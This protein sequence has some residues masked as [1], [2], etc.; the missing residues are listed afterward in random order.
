[1]SL[2]LTFSDIYTKVHNFTTAP[3]TPTGDDL[4]AAKDIVYRA[5]RRF[6]Y[7]VSFVTKKPHIWSW[8]IKEATLQLEAGKDTYLLPEDFDDLHRTFMYTMNTGRYGAITKTSMNKLMM[9]KSYNAE[10]SWPLMCATH[11][12]T[13]SKTVDQNKKVIFWPAP[14]GVYQ[15][16]YSYV[17]EPPKPTVATDLFLGNA[18]TDET[19]LQVCLAVAEQESDEIVG[20]QSQLADNQV[21][22]L[23]LKDTNDAPDTVGYVRDG[24]IANYGSMRDWVLK[25]S[26][27]NID[28]S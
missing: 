25:N 7:P 6:L 21:Q 19:L 16:N 23:I 26:T 1:M 28:Q 8:L 13:V 10:N 14:T 20:V 18:L 9:E 17:C 3:G 27:L 12:E 2:R 24:N 4:T 22:A 5:Y 11:P 15:L